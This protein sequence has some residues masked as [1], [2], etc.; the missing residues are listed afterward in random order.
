DATAHIT[1]NPFFPPIFHHQMGVTLVL[2][3]LLA[4]IFL[5]GFKEAIGLAVAIVGVYL[6][7]NV[8]VIGR[9]LG[10]VWQH[11]EYIPQWKAALFERHG[12][13]AMMLAVAVLLFP[14]LALGLSGFETGVAVMPL[15]KGDP[16]D[17]NSHVAGRIRNTKK[18]LGTAA[19]IMSV[20][21]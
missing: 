11:P 2:L 14:K 4:A 8:V 3:L 12:S 13:A 17:R 6:A 1:G 7:L 15:V 16:G 21:L 5:K 10:A 19:L 20:L 9:A 18:L